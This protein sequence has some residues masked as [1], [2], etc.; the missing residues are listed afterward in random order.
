MLLVLATRRTVGRL[1]ALGRYGRDGVGVIPEQTATES[2]SDFFGRSEARVRQSLT[3]M[4]GLEVA[5]EATAEAFVYGWENWGRVRAMDNP[6]GYLYTVGR[7]KGRRIA[8]RNRHGAL[9]SE[10]PVVGIPMIEPALPKALEG[11]TE[12]QRT[13]VMLVHCYQWSIGEVADHLGL[14][15][16]STQTHLERGMDSLRTDIGGT[17]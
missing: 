15:R 7:D 11:L 1:R 9:L 2:F 14:S 12:R 6:V 3:P 17:Q 5:R 13:V 16:S 10:V 4:L 8:K